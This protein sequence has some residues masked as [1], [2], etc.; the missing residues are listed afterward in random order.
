MAALTTEDEHALAHA[1]SEA[2]VDAIARHV[3]LLQT[4][5]LSFARQSVVCSLL[6]TLLVCC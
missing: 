4:I 1:A 2:V 3:G 6:A 5:I